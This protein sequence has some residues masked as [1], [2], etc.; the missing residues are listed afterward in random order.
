MNCS[1]PPR[2]FFFFKIFIFSQLQNIKFASQ[3][4]RILCIL[5]FGLSAITSVLYALVLLR[6]R[7]HLQVRA[8]RW[9]WGSTH[10]KCTHTISEDKS[11]CCV[12]SNVVVW[13]WGPWAQNKKKK[14]YS[15]ECIP[16]PRP[17]SWPSVQ[18]N[19]NPPSNP[20]ASSLYIL[21]QPWFKFTR[22]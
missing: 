17:N 16:P 9:L 21:N 10:N 19:P 4:V 3:W 13:S 7:S 18:I 11:Q 15:V 12:L 14:R 5:C 8:L 1:F 22:I 2:F 20:M 6:W